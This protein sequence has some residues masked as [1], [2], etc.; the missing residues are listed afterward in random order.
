MN[1]AT[2]DP[3]ACL[4]A[5]RRMSELL[6][7]P[8]EAELLSYRVEQELQPLAQ[9]AGLPVGGRTEDFIDRLLDYMKFLTGGGTHRQM[10]EIELTV[11]G[12]PIFAQLTQFCQNPTCRVKG[13]RVKIGDSIQKVLP[14]GGCHVQCVPPK[15]RSRPA[16]PC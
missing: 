9:A 10:P 4:Q 6:K 12:E 11:C 15:A 7:E 1:A 5:L 16:R 14:W 2:F 13:A 8:A 3:P